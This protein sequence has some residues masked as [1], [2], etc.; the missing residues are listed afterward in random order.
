[1]KKRI[2]SKLSSMDQLVEVVPW[3]MAPAVDNSRPLILFREKKGE[4]VLPVWVSHL[5]AGIALTQSHVSTQGVSPHDL[6]NGILKKLGVQ[7]DR[8]EFVQLKGH[9]QYVK[10]KFKGSEA[11][12][13]MTVRAD[14]V[15]SFCL[16][17]SCTFYASKNIIQKSRDVE[18]ELKVL[19]K[20]A[21]Q[22]PDLVRNPHPYLN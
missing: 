19:S 5:D 3:G 18:Q 20:G 4:M 14:H 7:V 2:R 8:C 11:L 21:A 15:V 1:M 22:V 13:D 9:H 17:S 10:I 6:A 16:R 12:E